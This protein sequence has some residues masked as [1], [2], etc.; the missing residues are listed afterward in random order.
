[1]SR[2]ILSVNE[3]RSIIGVS[4]SR[5]TDLACTK[6][7]IILSQE[8]RFSRV[9]GEAH[10]FL[11]T[12]ILNG[13]CRVIIYLDSYSFIFIIRINWKNNMLIDIDD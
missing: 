10:S 13:V 11:A 1:M 4:I 9:P 12:C 8:N 5:S 3:D 6:G 2:K 7:W